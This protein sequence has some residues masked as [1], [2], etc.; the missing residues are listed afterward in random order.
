MTRILLRSSDDLW[1]PIAQRPKAQRTRAAIPLADRWLLNT[2]MVPGP[3][4]HGQLAEWRRGLLIRSLDS[5]NP[6]TGT[7]LISPMARLR[8]EACC[9]SW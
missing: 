7:L 6:R 2:M 9:A 4:H 8:S 3:H 1:A 5:M